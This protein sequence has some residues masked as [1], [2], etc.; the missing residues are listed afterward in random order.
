MFFAND[1]RKL[2]RV[3]GLKGDGLEQMVKLTF[4]AGF[5]DHIAVELQQIQDVEKMSV[6]DVLKRARILASD[7]GSGSVV[8]PAIGRSGQGIKCFGCGGPHIVCNCPNQEKR[9]KKEVRCYQCGGG[10]IVKYCPHDKIGSGEKKNRGAERE[11]EVSCVTGIFKEIV[12]SKLSGVPVIDIRING[13]SVKALVDTGCTRTMVREGLTGRAT[14]ETVLAAFDG[15]EVKCKGL[16]H[17]EMSVG[18][19]TVSQEVMVMDWIVGG[20]DAVIGMDT[21]SRLGR[22]NLSNLA[23]CAFLPVERKGGQILMTKTSRPTLMV[24]RGRSGIF[25]LRVGHR[26]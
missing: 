6:G 22:R 21:I 23:K 25:G 5:P 19:E 14:G 18:E 3:C 11:N 17:A 8:A 13:K 20:I 2:A 15:L 16:A 24:N 9:E 12:R 4:I 1:I 10:H 7:S 26:S